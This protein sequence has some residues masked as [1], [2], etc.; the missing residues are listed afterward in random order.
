[1]CETKYYRNSLTFVT[2]VGAK[3][4]EASILGEARLTTNIL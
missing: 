2:P 1:M 4:A 3:T